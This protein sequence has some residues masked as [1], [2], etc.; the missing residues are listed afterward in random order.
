MKKF[1]FIILLVFLNGLT[2]LAT[3]IVGG[4]FYYKKTGTN[5]YQVTLKLYVDC[6]NGNPQAIQSDLQAIVS[7][8][9]ARTNTLIKK[10]TF[11]R[12]GPSR[13]NKI[14]YQCLVP[15][16]DVCVD[17]YVYTR[18][19]TIDVGTDGVIMAFQRCCRNNSI[20]NIITPESTGATY[21]VKIPGTNVTTN[22]SSAVFKELPPNYLCTDAPLQF[23]H[24][25]VDPDGDSLVYELYQPYKGATRDQPRPDNEFNGFF[26][27][28]PF[29]T[30]I[31][32]NNYST[33]N[34]V[35]G[36]PKM[37]IN[38]KT[39]ELTLLPN[40]VGQYVIGIKVLEY[41]DGKLIG[42][43]LRDY[44]FNVRKCKTT[45]VPNFQISAGSSALTVSCSDTVDF[46]N[47][48]QKAKEYFWNFGDPTTEADTSHEVNPRWI[49]PG[50]G[51]YLAVL[52]AS[53]DVCEAD[54]KFIVKIRSKI[55]VDLGPDLVFCDKVDRIITPKIF[56][57]DK[58]AWNTG[59]FGSYIRAQDTGM[60]KATVYYGNCSASDSTYLSLDPVKSPEIP[61]TFFCTENEVDI[62]L[63]AGVDNHHYRWS[64][65]FMDTF[66]TLHVTKSG[67]YW[68][69][70]RNRN[71][72]KTD[73]S[74][75]VVVDPDLPEYL[76][77][78][79]EFE[80]EFD[81]GTDLVPNATYLW[82][83]GSTE[84]Q[85]ILDTA[86]YHWVQ[87]S[88][89]HCVLTDSIFIEN[90]V[91]NLDIGP[92]S[93]YCDDLFRH[94]KAP[95]NMFS[96][97]WHD[98]SNSIDYIATLPG[99]YYV[100]VVDTNGC[101][102]SDT[103]LLTLSASPTISL[104][105]DTTICVRSI[106]SFGLQEKF[107]KY[108]W[109]N[110]ETT[111]RVYVSKE[112]AYILKVI[113]SLGCA[114]YDTVNV[115]VDPEAL[116]NN[117]FIPNAFSP[118][119]DGLNEVFPFKEDIAQPEYRVRIYNRWGEKLFDSELQGQ[120]WDGI[121]KGERVEQEAFIYQIEYRSC[122]GEQRRTK[123]TVTVME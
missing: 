6:Q 17:E 103:T 45:L 38:R 83:N 87:I 44:Q 70:I 65:S 37:E 97:A 110:G 48:S 54:Y 89:E 92:D 56:D 58:I 29:N 39:G 61:D 1:S 82:S 80:K 95:E 7:F 73:S 21:W 35:P 74:K 42:E 26:K 121:Y 41:R 22:N 64:T 16:M 112:G 108:K 23:D 5:R 116:P 59:R 77:V 113:D 32:G 12:T 52:H 2:A 93:N 71:C 111:P 27:A 79:N 43:T 123:G 18:N 4:D 120:Q 66:R 30:I 63:D 90:P 62:T 104:G 33:S 78:C 67:D 57:A 101:T 114:G 28:P 51:D 96:Y 14:H 75:I 109:N 115:F 15:P 91:I 119:G 47:R 85:T 107:T 20:N 122:S 13:L 31:W 3:H 11:N 40:V 46:I 118:N 81:G 84:R 117:L 49:Y 68:V 10:E 60:Y 72:S 94:M 99:K 86:G 88:Y 24:S 25:A 76:F 9:N 53:N 50:N 100:S 98:G 19:M 8:W 69:R 106:V 36:D 102:K 55:E 34:Q 105:N